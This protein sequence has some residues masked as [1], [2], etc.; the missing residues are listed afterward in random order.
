MLNNAGY[1]FV[2]AIEQARLEDVKAEFETNFFGALRV[3]QAAL[4][5]LRSQNCGHILGVSSVAGIVAGPMTGFYN[6]SK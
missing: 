4:P 1:A 6:A 2:G 3:I 5:I